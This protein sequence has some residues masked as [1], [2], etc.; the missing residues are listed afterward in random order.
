MNFFWRN[1]QQKLLSKAINFSSCNF[2]ICGDFNKD[3]NDFDIQNEK[4]VLK[5]GL[6][7]LY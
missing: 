7:C 3:I 5:N 1:Y 4:V 6:Q 2:V